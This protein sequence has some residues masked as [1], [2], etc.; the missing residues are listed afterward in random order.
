MSDYK[1]TEHDGL[2]K[3][4]QPD[5]RVGTGEFKGG[6]PVELGKKGGKSSGET[7]E[8]KDQE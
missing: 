2:R 1:P 3:D 8:E 7:Q 4:G 6:D 5:K